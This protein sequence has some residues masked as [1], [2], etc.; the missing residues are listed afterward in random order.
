MPRIVKSLETESK[1]VV[2]RGWEE[3]DWRMTANG[4]SFPFFERDCI[5]RAILGL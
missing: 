3:R 2:A 1:F 5:F 4:V